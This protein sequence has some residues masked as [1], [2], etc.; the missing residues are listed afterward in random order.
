MFEKTINPKC[1]DSMGQLVFR[2]EKI[3]EPTLRFRVCYIADCIDEYIM[4]DN[5]FG[6]IKEII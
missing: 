4:R 2:T 3:L 6:N 5:G 1:F